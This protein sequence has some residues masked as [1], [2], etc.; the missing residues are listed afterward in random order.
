MLLGFDIG[1]TK[2]SVILGKKTGAS[3]MGISVIDKEILATAQPAGE[4]IGALFAA[5]NRLMAKNGFLNADIEGIGI[6]C[7]GPLDSKRGMILSPPNLPGWDN[8]AIG[9]MVEDRF[10]RRPMLQN[11]ANA[12][13]LAEWKYGAGVGYDNVI[14]LTFGTGMGAGLILNGQLYSGK[15]DLAGEVG[16]MR[17]AETGPMGYGKAGSFEGYCSGGGIARLAMQKA[18]EQLRNGKQVSFCASED[19]LPLITA[20]IVAEAALAGDVLAK[21]IYATCG[22]YLGKGL[23]ALIDILNPEVII[24]GSIYAKAQQLTE[25]AM[26]EV[27]EKEAL[28]GAYNAC[29]IVPADLGDNIGDIAALAVAVG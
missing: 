9:D 15:T 25:A 4:L 10:G 1:G 18:A 16:H 2:C 21:S 28:P 20:K 23:A 13:A 19:G 26:R 27:I 12:C 11:D 29:K 7:G 3:G 6:S 14:F 24:L 17:I 22:Y 8:I 5:A